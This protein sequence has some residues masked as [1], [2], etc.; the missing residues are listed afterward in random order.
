MS[1]NEFLRVKSIIRSEYMIDRHRVIFEAGNGWHCA[2]AEFAKLDSCRH[3]RESEGRRAAQ[4]LIQQRVRS[5]DGTVAGFANRE[6][7]AVT[8]HVTTDRRARR[9]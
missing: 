6:H 9:K 8:P 7:A 4:A 5:V 3:T 2:C 1:D